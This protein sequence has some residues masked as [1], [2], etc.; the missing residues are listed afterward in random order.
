M[1]RTRVV[2]WSLLFPNFVL[3]GCAVTQDLSLVYS[4]IRQAMFSLVAGQNS[5]L[6]EIST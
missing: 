5:A 4:K 6:K 1:A 3:S 2:V